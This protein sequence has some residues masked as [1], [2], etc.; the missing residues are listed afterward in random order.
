MCMTCAW[1][2]RV[3]LFAK[4][5]RC[6]VTLRGIGWLSP[7]AYP[8]WLS[9]RSVSGKTKMKLSGF[10]RLP[11]IT[12][13]V[14]WPCAG[15]ELGTV[16][17]RLQLSAAGFSMSFAQAVYDL[18]W[19]FFSQSVQQAPASATSTV[20]MTCGAFEKQVDAWTWHV[21]PPVGSAPVEAETPPN[22]SSGRAQP[23]AGR[24]SMPES[25]ASLFYLPS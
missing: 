2:K 12:P 1:W 5:S 9:A 16:E 22:S 25:S 13:L 17:N 3:P 19:K 23:S 20:P 4:A 6:G 18:H 8:P 21:A 14:H 10:G 24:I 7:S 15:A 11:E